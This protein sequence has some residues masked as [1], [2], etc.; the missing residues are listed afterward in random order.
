MSAGNIYIAVQHDANYREKRAPGSFCCVAATIR[1]ICLAVLKFRAMPKAT[2]Y[3][4]PCRLTGVL[5]CRTRR[6]TVLKLHESELEC[7]GRKVH[8]GDVVCQPGGQ[9]AL[10]GDAPVDVRALRACAR[11]PFQQRLRGFARRTDRVGQCRGDDQRFAAEH[12]NA[13]VCVKA[14]HQSSTPV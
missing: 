14:R 11:Q 3:S 10:D 9:E 8:Q 7:P 1:Y 12:Y 4:T 2:G 5:P 13:F 6:N